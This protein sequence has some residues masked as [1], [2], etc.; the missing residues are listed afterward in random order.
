M[1]EHGHYK[2]LSVPTTHY[3][4]SQHAFAVCY[5]SMLKEKSSLKYI[6]YFSVQMLPTFAGKM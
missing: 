4:S 3:A 6:A 2:C 5:D 1:Y